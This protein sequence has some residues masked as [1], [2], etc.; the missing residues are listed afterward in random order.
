LAGHAAPADATFIVTVKVDYVLAAVDGTCYYGLVDGCGLREAIAEANAASGNKTI[1]FH[2]SM[3]T[4][5]G[6]AR[7]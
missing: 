5:P 6:V 7:R 2:S 3:A 4:L 1:N